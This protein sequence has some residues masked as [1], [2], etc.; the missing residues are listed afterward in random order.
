VSPSDG[1]RAARIRVRRELALVKPCAVCREY[2]HT[3]IAHVG[4]APR[5]VISGPPANTNGDGYDR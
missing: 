3:A 5:S 4:Q 1:I 2:G